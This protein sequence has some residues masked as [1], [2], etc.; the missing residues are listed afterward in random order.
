MKLFFAPNAERPQARQRREI[1][2]QKLCLLC[3]VQ[4]NCLKFA[5]EHHEY[6]YWGGESEEQRHLAGFTVA[7]PI[8]IRARQLQKSL[9]KN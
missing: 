6:G 2:A 7:A 8:G 3:S 9:I 1:K 5:R 4:A